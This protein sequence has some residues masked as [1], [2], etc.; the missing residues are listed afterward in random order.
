MTKKTKIAEL[1][2]SIS[3]FYERYSA[4]RLVLATVVV[5]VGSLLASWLIYIG[6]QSGLYA[7]I[8]FLLF[9]FIGINVAF[10]TVV[11]PASQLKQAKGLILAAIKDP[12]RIKSYDMKKV[13]LLDGQGKVHQLGARELGVWTS[14]VVPY[15]I[16]EPRA[17]KGVQE[18][19]QRKLTASERKYI[20]QRRKEVLEMEKNIE[21]ERAKLE[22][23][24]RELE[25]RSADLKEAEDLVIARLTGVEQAEA[26]IEQLKIVAAERADVDA[27]AYDA[28]A[29]ELKAA[30]L[31]AKEAE[32]V[33]L[34]E[35]LARDR[36]NFESQKLELQQLQQ[37]VMSSPFADS[38]EAAAD[39]S[40]E[41]REAALLERQK[42]L[43]AEAA[44]LEM[45]SSF[46]ADSENLLIERLD[47]LTEREAHIEQ[48]E[49]DAG[50]RQ[51]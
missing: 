20:E 16:T 33:E 49:I 41:A 9:G 27:V 10:L 36:H 29:A 1:E 45:R 25:V 14:L 47:A 22:K 39:Q 4:R 12:E 38:E 24:R 40:I 26:E 8:A 5:A 28:R 46:V 50:L 44:E 42:Q 2:D 6:L 21:N 3:R 32:L 15:L 31:K 11:P 43:E 48:S 19:P 23:D 17:G 13:Q 37:T 51:D 35:R 34:K 30:E 7:A 18:R